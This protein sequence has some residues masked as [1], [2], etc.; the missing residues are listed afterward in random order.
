MGMPT[1]CRSGRRRFTLPGF[2]H[3]L[4]RVFLCLVGG[5]RPFFAAI[6]ML[7]PRLPDD[8][9]ITCDSG[10]VAAWYARDLRMR[11]GMMGSLSGGLATMG[12]AMPYGMAAKFAYPQRPVIAL[13]GDGAMQMNGISAMITLAH[14]WR[15]WSDPR[16]VI[17]VLNNSDLNMVTWEQRG[18]EGEPKF[19]ASQVLPGFNYAEYAKLLGL[20]GIRVERAQ[21]VGIAWEEALASDRP[22]L[23]EMV[24][25]P[26]VPPVP[27]HVSSK[28]VRHYARALL[29]GDPQALEVMKATAKEWWDS[30]K[31]SR[32]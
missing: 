4:R 24:T 14:H 18:T 22:T 32:G 3:R 16:F 1:L 19:E 26:N 10:T 21:T 30:I 7:S 11:R 9:I 15:K 5:D 29:Q 2:D 23:L 6:S 12:C 27:P 20:R 25:D 13:A 28:Q 17:C 8:A 31:P